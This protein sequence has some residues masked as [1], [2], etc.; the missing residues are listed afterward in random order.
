MQ[1]VQSGDQEQA[2]ASLGSAVR[3]GGADAQRAIQQNRVLAPVWQQRAQR[4]Q[5]LLGL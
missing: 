3:Y 2:G 5:G 1:D 4:T